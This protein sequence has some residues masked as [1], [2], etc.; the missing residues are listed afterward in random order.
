M[1]SSSFTAKRRF[2]TAQWVG[3]L[4]FYLFCD[5]I[6]FLAKFVCLL[7]GKLSLLCLNEHKRSCNYF[8][9][10]K[11]VPSSLSSNLVYWQAFRRHL[12]H[13]LHKQDANNLQ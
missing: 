9:S 8:I 12:S 4:Y 13:E 3:R 5:R 1:W 2:W 7:K 11:K 10:S 6:F